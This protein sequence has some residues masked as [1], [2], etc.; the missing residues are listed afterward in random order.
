[1]YWGE[2]IFD[3]THFH[4][5]FGKNYLKSSMQCFFDIREI[6][7]LFPSATFCIELNSSV[8]IRKMELQ[9]FQ[10]TIL[11]YFLPPIPSNQSIKK[12]YILYLEKR[13][14]LRVFKDNKVIINSIIMIHFCSS[15]FCKHFIPCNVCEKASQ[16]PNHVINPNQTFLQK[17][18]FLVP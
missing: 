3:K 1:M 13:T 16:I 12:K 8:I 2:I 17:C 5:N 11:Y 15:Y 18:S 6:R 9:L 7:S 4:L 10:R 14:S